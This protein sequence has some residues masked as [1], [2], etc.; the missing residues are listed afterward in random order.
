MRKR[1]VLGV[2][3]GLAGVGIVLAGTVVALSAAAHSPHINFAQAIMAGP[4]HWVIREPYYSAALL[5]AVA[6]GLVG[7]LSCT[8]G[9]SL[10]V[11]AVVSPQEPAP[12]ARKTIFRAFEL[13][14]P[15]REEQ[16]RAES[17]FATR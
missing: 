1:F 7:L 15:S 13:H 17:P 3:S 12:V 8:F 9:L 16:V 4:D 11:M 10:F 6:L 14:Q 2:L 5:V